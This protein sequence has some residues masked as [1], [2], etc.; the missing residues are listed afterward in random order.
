VTRPL[1]VIAHEATRTGSPRVLIDLMRLAEGRL[2]VPVAMELLAEG[3]LSE[4]LRA[5]ATTDRVDPPPPAAILLNSAAAASQAWRFDQSIPIAA[6]VH[7][8]GNALE[9]L[10]EDCRTALSS[11]CDRVLCVSER[12]R[13]D[14]ATMGVPEEQLEVLLPVVPSPPESTGVHTDTRATLGLDA[15]LPLVVGCGEAGWRK[16]A[17]LF[18]DVARRTAH[19]L[20][21]QFAWAGRRP[22]A[23][24]RILDN[25]TRAASLEGRLHWLGELGE[26]APLLGEADLLLMTSREDPQPL[27]PLEAAGYGT[28]TAGFAVGGLI[29]LAADGAAETVPYPD[30]PALARIIVAL[31]DDRGRRA[32]LTSAAVDRARKRHSP[33]EVGGRF[34][35]VLADLLAGRRP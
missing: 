15:A 17:D 26:L 18:I 16:G 21:C 34:V 30:T 33:D 10:P 5:L 8:E 27:V 2:G 24:A 7:E 13:R 4:E 12:S 11:R 1:L 22:R 29:D 25:D 14:L 20:P 32:A 3:P 23:F 35:Q 9:V 28:A 19:Q 31:L 6:Y